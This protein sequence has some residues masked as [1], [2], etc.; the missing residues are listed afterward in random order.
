M[1]LASAPVF[2]AAPAQAAAQQGFPCE[3]DI[4]KVDKEATSEITLTIDCP[5]DQ[6]VDAKIITGG[7]ESRLRQTVPAGVRQNST[8]T[9]N[10]V[11]QVC[12]ELEADRKSTTI[13][14]S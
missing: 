7:N 14:A 11:P 4:Q 5:K 3:A 2:A 9:V 1:L 6:T 13:C 8:F 10:K 12:A